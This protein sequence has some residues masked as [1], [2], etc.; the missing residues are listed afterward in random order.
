MSSQLNR[1]TFLSVSAAGLGATAIG[2]SPP[3]PVGTLRP[4]VVSSANGLKTVEKAMELIRAG[5]TVFGALP[6]WG[7]FRTAARRWRRR[8][9]SRSGLC[10]ACGYDLRATPGRCPECGTVP[11]AGKG[12]A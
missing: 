5:V 3:K 12:A 11:A 8:R 7:L 10:S 6:A 1:R 4:V 9:A 2:A